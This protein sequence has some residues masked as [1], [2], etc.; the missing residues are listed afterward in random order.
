MRSGRGEGAGHWGVGSGFSPSGATV[1]V[2]PTPK[3]WSAL[4]AGHS[5]R[6]PWVSVGSPA[7]LT[8][9]GQGPWAASPIWGGSG[10]HAAVLSWLWRPQVQAVSG[11]TPRL[12]HRDSFEEHSLVSSLSE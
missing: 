2:G 6:A 9:E 11:V 8:Q 3:D 10:H 5:L 7:P 4:G 1:T 12:C